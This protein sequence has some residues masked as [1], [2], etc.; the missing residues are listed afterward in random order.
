MDWFNLQRLIL[1]CWCFP[2][3]HIHTQCIFQNI[4]ETTKITTTTKMQKKNS[5]QIFSFP[6][7]LFS[8][9]L[10]LSLSHSFSLCLSLSLG[11][12]DLVIWLDLFNSNIAWWE[13][14]KGNLK[15]LMHSETSHD[16]ICTIWSLWYYSLFSGRVQFY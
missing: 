4:R 5:P 14:C 13:N 6:L 8:L 7:F 2:L 9:P 10:F 16:I 11:L 15:I 1:M 12:Y 3:K